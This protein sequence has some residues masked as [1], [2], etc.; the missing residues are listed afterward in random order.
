MHRIRLARPDDA[1]ALLLR[2]GFEVEGL[3]RRALDRDG[4]VI[5]EYYMGRLLSG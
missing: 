4:T 5:D 2:C 3:R 1:A